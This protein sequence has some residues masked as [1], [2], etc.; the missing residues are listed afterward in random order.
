M[1]GLVEEF[2]VLVKLSE[3]AF[4]RVEAERGEGFGCL[5]GFDLDVFGEEILID[6]EAGVTGAEEAG[7]LSVEDL[8]SG[9]SRA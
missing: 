3:Q 9:R 8:P 7:G 5:D 2:A 6:V 4:S 1:A